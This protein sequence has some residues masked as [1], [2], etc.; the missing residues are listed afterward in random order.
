MA[1]FALAIEQEGKNLYS[2]P[3]TIVD[4]VVDFMF[5]VDI[6]INLRTT[7]VDL[8]GDFVSRP[9][10]IAKHYIKTWFLIDVVAAIPFEL[11]YMIANTQ[12]VKK[13]IL[14]ITNQ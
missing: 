5:V 13:F 9:R 3:L 7:Y 2:H 6:V 11:L 8:N 1:S 4:Y 10:R 12:Q 14:V